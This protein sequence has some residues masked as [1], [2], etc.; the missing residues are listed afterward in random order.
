MK[1][2]EKTRQEIEASIEAIARRL[3]KIDRDLTREANP[4][5]KDSEESAV[6]L[7]NDQVL[8]ELDREGREQLAKMQETLRRIDAG[9]YGKCA[10]CQQPIAAVR[11]KALPY[12]ELCIDCARKLDRG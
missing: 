2:L 8:E 3:Q 9:S 1:T 11:L 6:T 10:R 12:A 5:S 7:Q 4:L